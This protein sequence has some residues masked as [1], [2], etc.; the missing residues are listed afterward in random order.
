MI[1]DF[2]L[3]LLI[4]ASLQSMNSNNLLALMI[5]HNSM[6]KTR[7]PAD[8]KKTDCVY[9]MNVLAYLITYMLTKL[10][11]NPSRRRVVKILQLTGYACVNSFRLI[12]MIAKFSW[13]VLNGFIFSFGFLSFLDFSIFVE[14][15]FFIFNQRVLNLFFDFS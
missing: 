5:M 12:P 13:I 1:M 9:S 10:T 4:V 11:P 3:L 7:A 15:C 8:P 2:H 14:C 6:T